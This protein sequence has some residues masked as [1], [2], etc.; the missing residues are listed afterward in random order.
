KLKD[1]FYLKAGA[2]HDG[3]LKTTLTG[4]DFNDGTGV[5]T[6]VTSSTIYNYSETLDQ[7]KRNALLSTIQIKGFAGMS[8]EDVIKN[9]NAD[10]SGAEVHVQSFTV[11]RIQGAGTD[12]V[13]DVPSLS[14]N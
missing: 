2:Q 11:Y 1:A 14:I 9:A 13:T 7:D 10:V 12:H 6:R 8:L 4:A 5:N 3:A